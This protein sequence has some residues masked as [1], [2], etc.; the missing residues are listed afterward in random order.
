VPVSEVAS[1][2]QLR[3]A[4]RHQLLLIPRYRLRTFG[5]R[6]F[7]VAGPTF[8]NSLAD[9]LPTYSSDRFKPAL[10][11]FLFAT[12][13]RIQRIRG[14]RGDA[15]YKLMNLTS[16]LAWT[17]SGSATQHLTQG[18][19]QW[20]V[21]VHVMCTRLWLGSS[22]RVSTSLG[23]SGLCRTV[24][25]GTGTLQKEMA[26]YRHWSVSRW[27]DPDYVS[28]C[29]ILSPDNTE[30]RL[31][32]G[33]KQRLHPQSVDSADEDAVSWLTSC[34]SWHTYEKKKKTWIVSHS[35]DNYYFVNKWDTQYNNCFCKT[36]IL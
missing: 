13:W 1:R 6:A 7:A 20:T 3:S 32:S 19:L 14:F 8:W 28:H 15:L 17:H 4:S 9:A 33:T 25:H 31:I 10:K 11:T 23:N 22:N 2:Q 18:C 24:S 12:L 5:R 21:Y 35:S 29:R 26:T 30:W 27:W 34:G 36:L 16:T